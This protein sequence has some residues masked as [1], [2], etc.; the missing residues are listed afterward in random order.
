MLMCIITFLRIF[1]FHKRDQ[2]NSGM[3]GQVSRILFNDLT[4]R[5]CFLFSLTIDI[6]LL[7]I[8]RF[9]ISVKMKIPREFS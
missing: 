8:Q 5:L 6:I 1:Y 4:Q 3:F 7:F 2:E 9:K